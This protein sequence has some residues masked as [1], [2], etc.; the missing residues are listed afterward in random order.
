MIKIEKEYGQLQRFEGATKAEVL[1]LVAERGNDTDIADEWNG[2]PSAQNLFDNLD[3]LGDKITYHGYII[4][5]STGRS[6]WR[7]T[8]EGFNGDNLTADQALEIMSMYSGADEISHSK[9]E[10]GTY[11]VY[12]WWD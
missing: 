2:F 3:Q 7:V 10:D 12:A 11:S 6:D 8:V 5:K 1:K 9:N 4:D